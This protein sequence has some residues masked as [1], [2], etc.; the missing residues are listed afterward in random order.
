MQEIFK[1]YGTIIVFLHILSAVVWVGGMIAIRFA[2][3]PSLQSIEDAHVRLGKTLQIVGRLFHIV[4]PFILLSA[5]CGVFI[6]KGVGYSGGIIHLKEAIWTL[7]SLNFIYMY[8]KRAKA[9]T[10]YI[11]GELAQAKE[12]VKLLPT[13][14]LPIN[15]VLGLMAIFAGV[16][17]RGF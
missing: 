9:Q 3:H 12:M 16:M 11:K 6:L 14:L 7:M 17:L 13:V 1:N 2:V 8:I 5:A 4:I 15:I 10:L